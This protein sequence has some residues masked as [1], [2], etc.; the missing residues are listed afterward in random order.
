VEQNPLTPDC[1]IRLSFPHPRPRP[2]PISN[3]RDLGQSPNSPTI[4]CQEPSCPESALAGRW[5]PD[6]FFCLALASVSFLAVSH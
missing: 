1:A 4:R 5:G 3:S 6:T 2:H